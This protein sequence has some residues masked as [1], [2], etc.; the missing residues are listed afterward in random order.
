V[1]LT[2]G[3]SMI[4]PLGGV[5]SALQAAE[6][7]PQDVMNLLEEALVPPGVEVV[8]DQL[9]R[10]E[11]VGLHPPGASAL[12]HVEQGIDHLTAGVGAAAPRLAGRLPLRREAVL[13][14]LTLA[15]GQVAGVSHSGTHTESD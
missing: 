2:V 14:V 7:Y 15:V 1:V 5:A 8:A 4:P 13:D 6:V 10:G 11:V 12:G 9:P 3:L